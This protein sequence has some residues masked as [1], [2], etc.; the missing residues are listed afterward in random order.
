[1][2]EE[3]PQED[4][5]IARSASDDSRF[6]A[7][8]EDD[9]RVAYGYLMLDGKIVGDVWLYNVGA[10]P[11]HLPKSP[12][13]LDGCP[14]M[15]FPNTRGFV[16]PG[17]FARVSSNAEI[18]FVWSYG[19]SG[20]FAGVEFWIRGRRHGRVTPGSKPGWCV[21]A[22]KDGPLAQTLD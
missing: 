9:G 6:E 12:G 3:G 10:A 19:E 2:I 15:P 20:G 21:L 16:A 7:V 8:F 22:S 11:E 5:I 17:L 13:V 4:C 14:R 1:M 18:S